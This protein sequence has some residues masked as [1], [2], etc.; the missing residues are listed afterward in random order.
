M[1]KI[2]PQ[3]KKELERLGYKVDGN[4]VKNEKGTVAS[5][6]DRGGLFS[7]SKEVSNILSKNWKVPEKVAT[8]PAKK[9]LEKYPSRVASKKALAPTSSKKPQTRPV[10]DSKPY[11]VSVPPKQ[12]KLVDSIP[13]VKYTRKTSPETDKTAAQQPQRPITPTLSKTKL[14]QR[15]EQV[16]KNVKPGLNFTDWKRL[17]PAK[18][19]TPGEALREYQKYKVKQ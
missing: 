6:N 8:Q 14:A 10:R 13:T 19:W 5:F 2:S 11:V 9:S 18:K 7:G 17:Y 3:Q 4:F 15:Y 12:P 1:S 16:T